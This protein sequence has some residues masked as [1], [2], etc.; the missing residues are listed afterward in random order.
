MLL[1]R[2]NAPYSN[3]EG[4]NTIPLSCKGI[5]LRLVT[6]L[7][8]KILIEGSDAGYWIL[9]AGYWMLDAGYWML[10]AGCWMLDVD[11]RLPTGNWELG[12]GNLKLD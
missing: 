4:A 1:E 10:D 9:D 11:C 7:G 8:Q 3:K 2:G 5:S 6:G 12:T